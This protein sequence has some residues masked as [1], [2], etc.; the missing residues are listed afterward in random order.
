[1]RQYKNITSSL[2]VVILVSFNCNISALDSD[3]QKEVPEKQKFGFGMMF[4][5]GIYNSMLY[6]KDEY[7]NSTYLRNNLYNCVGAGF[8]FDFPISNKAR[9]YINP[10][11]QLVDV[12]R[13]LFS[14]NLTFQSFLSRSFFIT[15]GGSFSIDNYSYGGVGP[16]LGLGFKVGRRHSFFLSS[17]LY[18]TK[19]P[20][21]GSM[22]T[23]N[24]FKVPVQL[25]YRIDFASTVSKKRKK[26]SFPNTVPE[27]PIPDVPS[28]VMEQK[29]N[30]LQKMDSIPVRPSEVL[31]NSV[32]Q[33]QEQ[34][35]V[36]SEEKLI[37]QPY[38]E[39]SAYSYSDLKDL[40]EL[41][42]KKEDYQ[43]A[44]K[45][46]DEIVK[47]ENSDNLGEIPVSRL[48]ELIEEAIKSENYIRAALLQD[49]I[50]HRK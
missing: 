18:Y 12:K 37:I 19:L 26:T 39:L 21:L 47:R 6:T 15:Y 40:L 17:K 7:Y 2:L 43:M 11:I 10:D 49:E 35:P 23:Y 29:V 20:D 22:I 25:G 44:E 13:V 34:A 41:T 14:F 3:P 27:N 30:Q 48:K 1:M 4:M 31:G 5:G 42:V 16:N 28:S 24:S 46:Q 33:I 45:I 32:K 50:N 38:K 36:Q 8:V 9:F